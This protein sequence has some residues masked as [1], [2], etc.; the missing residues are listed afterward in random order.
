MNFAE[1]RLVQASSEFDNIRD[2]Y[3]SIRLPEELK[4]HDSRTGVRKEDQQQYNR[5][6]RSARM[7]ETVFRILSKI[8]LDEPDSVNALEER[9]GD[10]F[11]VQFALMKYLQD[12]Y[13]VLMVSGTTNQETAKIFRSLRRNTSAFAP[14]VIE[15]LRSA[16]TVVAAG[17]YQQY[18]PPFRGGRSGRG[19]G[20]GFRGG[21]NNS[22]GSS[23]RGY[24]NFRN[25]Q[26]TSSRG[27]QDPYS[28]LGR[29]V[30]YNRD[31]ED[32]TNH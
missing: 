14:D 27:G 12:E 21:F 5:L 29:Q 9:L 26:G 13:A 20:F 8:D 11:M 2:K 18:R 16:A 17:Q 31:S 7:T 23:N 19:R 10:L 30:P 32:N 1:I 24:Y 6:V 15:D 22:F 4:L 25:S 28:Q 3:K